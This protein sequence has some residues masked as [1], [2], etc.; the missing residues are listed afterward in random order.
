MN[1]FNSFFPTAFKIQNYPEAKFKFTSNTINVKRCRL[2]THK[3]C[4]LAAHFVYK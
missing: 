2:K 1:S 4:R 3:S